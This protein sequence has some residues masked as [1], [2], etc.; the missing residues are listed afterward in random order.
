[1]FKFPRKE[2]GKKGKRNG[3]RGKGRGK[4]GKERKG[5]RGK[6]EGD[7]CNGTEWD[8]ILGKKKNICKKK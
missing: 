7:K 5:G 3:R 4:E 1:M 2:K 6:K 8:G